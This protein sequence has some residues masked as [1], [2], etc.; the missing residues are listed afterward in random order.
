MYAV[1][2]GAS[3][4]TR[5]AARLLHPA[6]QLNLASVSSALG[7][8]FWFWT[9]RLRHGMLFRSFVHAFWQN[10]RNSMDGCGASFSSKAKYQVREPH[11]RLSIRLCC[12]FHTMS[13]KRA[14]RLARRAEIV[15]MLFVGLG[16]GTETW[17]SRFGMR[18]REPGE[19]DSGFEGCRSDAVSWWLSGQ[20][21]RF[22]QG[23]RDASQEVS[24]KGLWLRSIEACQIVSPIAN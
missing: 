1:A 23:M 4:R 11:L 9:S 3:I 20:I 22:R 5:S 8:L 16:S 15:R 12:F 24:G 6:A 21:K 18:N 17:D 10:E 13:A 7:C 14:F 19:W 2:G